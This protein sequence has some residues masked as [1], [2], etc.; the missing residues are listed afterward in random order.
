MSAPTT[1][2]LMARLQQMQAQAQGAPQPAAATV[3][4]PAPFQPPPASAVPAAPGA[5]QPPPAFTAP[6]TPAALPTGAVRTGLS[7]FVGRDAQGRV[8]TDLQGRRLRETTIQT[9]YV[10]VPGTNGYMPIEPNGAA[11]T[12]VVA[13]ALVADA[14]A[15]LREAAAPPTQGWAPA[16]Q[17]PPP[18]APVQQPPAQTG[19]INPP[20]WQPAPTAAQVVGAQVAEASAPAAPETT[21]KKRGR[22]AKNA[23]APATPATV[24]NDGRTQVENIDPLDGLLLFVRCRPVKGFGPIMDLAD[25]VARV[26]PKVKEQ[27]QVDDF[28]FID[29]GKGQGLL[30]LL[31]EAEVK[32]LVDAHGSIALHVDPG[33]REASV[34][35]SKLVV[36]ATSVVRG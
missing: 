4:Q 27:A 2:D 7:S 25:I 36:L 29:Y 21:P 34:C 10:P 31:V 24:S 14:D 13:H 32:S 1:S 28:S 22:P 12:D 23:A 30:A 5:F 20:E 19:P 3:P 9:Q 26:Q 6:A 11:I 16:G 18:A 15:A 35:L 8:T 33:T 17:T